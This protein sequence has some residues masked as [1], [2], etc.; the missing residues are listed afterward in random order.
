LGIKV[1]RCLFA[2]PP[3]QKMGVGGKLSALWMLL[4]VF[5]F[6]GLI[7]PSLLS[8]SGQHKNE[9]MIIRGEKETNELLFADAALNWLRSDRKDGEILGRLT[10]LLK[11][12]HRF[13]DPVEDEDAEDKDFDRNNQ[14]GNDENELKMAKGFKDS[15]SMIK[16]V[17]KTRKSQKSNDK[18]DENGDQENDNE[19]ADEFHDV[20]NEDDAAH[21]HNHSE[22]EEEVEDS[23]GEDKDIN[24]V[25]NEPTRIIPHIIVRSQNNSLGNLADKIWDILAKQAKLEGTPKEITDADEIIRLKEL[26]ADEKFL[27]PLL[28]NGPNNQNRGLKEAIFIAHLLNRTL[29]LPNIMVHHMDFGR[30]NKVIYDFEEVFDRRHLSKY[31]RVVDLRTYWAISG[32]RIGEVW[33][34]R[35][36]HR[37][38]EY[39]ISYAALQGI[40]ISE[41]S[42]TRLNLK[43]KLLRE[44]DMLRFGS[45]DD[46]LKILSKRKEPFAAVSCIFCSFVM[47]GELKKAYLPAAK[48]LRY[49]EIY[50]QSFKALDFLQGEPYLAIHIRDFERNNPCRKEAERTK[51]ICYGLGNPFYLLDTKCLVNRIY[52]LVKERRV[53]RVYFAM[54]RG[55]EILKAKLKAKGITSYNL[56]DVLPA[57]KNTMKKK[58]GIHPEN[59]VIS[60]FEQ[61]ICM[62]AQIFMGT[63][64]S[65]WTHFVYEERETKEDRMNQHLHTKC[66]T[67]YGYMEKWAPS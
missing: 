66:S 29:V 45:V 16:D 37:C 22:A 57:L 11:E 3:H 61:V 8:Y 52:T 1:D 54:K 36:G 64:Q 65:T 15:T 32:K 51:E 21:D 62:E 35:V 41:I 12:E 53:A 27:V 33:P 46:V 26:H 59:F 56:D 48:H 63:K 2:P 14:M 25:K 19:D 4:L 20:N 6:S 23:S 31:V 5:A 38:E 58:L 49:A 44:S 24:A 47:R 67:V 60:G 42:P 43:A 7:L 17:K 13:V 34:L 10:T 18:L 55:Y 39:E 30:S 28:M 50:Y 40:D 9:A